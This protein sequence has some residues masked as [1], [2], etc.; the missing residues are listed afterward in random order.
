[1]TQ[2]EIEK[3]YR[4]F[5]LK[6]P[7]RYSRELAERLKAPTRLGADLH[8]MVGPDLW[9]RQVYSGRFDDREAWERFRVEYERRASENPS[10][11]DR[12]SIIDSDWQPRPIDTVPEVGELLERLTSELLPVAVWARDN[13]RTDPEYLFAQYLNQTAALL[14]TGEFDQIFVKWLQIS[15]SGSVD[16]AVLPVESTDD[17][18]EERA[19]FEGLVTVVDRPSTRTSRKD[20]D[21]FKKAAAEEFGSVP[22]DVKVAVVN[23]AMLSGWLGVKQREISA[24]NVPNDPEIA[25]VAGNYL[26]YL[27]Y[28]RMLEKTN[29]KSTEWENKGLASKLYETLGVKGTVWDMIK[30]TEGHE[31]S[32]GYREEGE[33]RHWGALR[34]VGREAWATYRALV[35]SSAS[36]VTENFRRRVARG[37]LAYACD[38]VGRFISRI[39]NP[40]AEDQPTLDD[41]IGLNKYA[42]GSYVLL[43]QGILSGALNI[44]KRGIE[45]DKLI[46]LAEEWD[47]K[48]AELAAEGTEDLAR[49]YMQD[50]LT[51]MRVYGGVDIEDD[52]SDHSLPVLV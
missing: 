6:I 11:R 19:S 34:A 30:Y 41:L 2:Q 49:T 45:V 32:H 4:D 15:T 40:L 25:E 12:Y 5:N 46:E 1:M 31:Y 18:L 39:K 38:D 26:I 42:F 22:L 44:S 14:P 27:F 8:I 52:C 9:Y 10:L 13:A 50:L 20:M 48:L 51:E 24:F 35:L 36:H 33:D 43:R 21:I 23:A 3:P 16:W 17:P 7:D 28:G 37:A 47:K 29:R